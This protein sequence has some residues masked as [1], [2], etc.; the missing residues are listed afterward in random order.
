MKL[1][2]RWII[3]LSSFVLIWGTH[4][5]LTP[6]SYLMS[7]RVLTRHMRDIMENIS[8]LTLEQSYNHLSKAKSAASLAK[9]LLSSN[10]VTSDNEG[11]RAL[12]RYFFDQL[13]I[14]PHLAGIY[15]GTPEGNFFYVSRYEE[16]VK[17]GFRTKIIRHT[18][19]GRRTELIYRNNNFNLMTRE[20]D[21][22][23]PYDPRTRPWFKNVLEHKHVAWT[24]PYIFYTSQKPGITIAGP[25]Y[26]EKG[27]LKGIVG[28]DI[29]I[30][31]LSLFVSKLRVGKSGKAF[32][33]NRN[34]DV[35]AYENL[36]KHIVGKNNGEGL[37][38][39]KV[40]EL[41]DI[42]AKKAFDSVHWQHD[43]EGNLELTASTFASFDHNG[44][45]Y[46]SMFTPFPA[47]R[48]PWIIGVY[49]PEDDYLGT[50][51]SNRFFNIIA[52]VVISIIASI[53]GLIFAQKIIRPVERLAE[54]AKAIEELDIKTS[55][56]INSVFK[57]LQEAANSFSRMK[58]SLVNYEGKLREN[59]R[60]YMAI[61]KTANDAI[62]MMDDKQCIS[63]LNPAAEKMFGYTL[64]ESIGLNLH[65]LFSPKRNVPIYEKGLKKFAKDGSG[66]FIDR[67]VTVQA[68]NQVG[69]K[70]PVE[71]S[72]SSLKIND[73][74]HA[75][76][77][78]RNITERKKA[79]QLRKRLANDLHDGIG[80]S[81][82]N[83]KLFAEMTMA[84]DVDLPTKNNLDAIAAISDDCLTEIRHYMNIL[85]DTEP[86]W[87]NF[88]AELHQ[89]CARTLEPH[90]ISFSMSTDL[91]NTAPPP[92][93]V[94][95]INVFKI[96]KEAVNNVIKHSNGDSM[97]LNFKVTDN[98]IL[99]IMSDNGTAAETSK[100][101]GRGLLSMTSR[102]KELG[103]LLTISWDGGV[104]INL[105]IP[106]SGSS[107]LQ[108][109]PV[110]ESVVWPVEDF[111]G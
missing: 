32:I 95:Y 103:G 59:N 86:K 58:K 19:E 48:L 15:V 11:I 3:F 74:W 87:D 42:I 22:D 7:E 84:H 54:E 6:S 24:N 106:F 49:L 73:A 77:I 44:D 81:L 61:T 109:K 5:I 100:S 97:D 8:D 43:A 68:I 14:Y 102:A 80:G 62:V 25:S 76:A 67:T 50:I 60:L 31:E 27:E 72:L 78:I 33:L 2:I 105:I 9:Q 57:E 51:K 30:A 110:D 53:L 75:V 111:N 66:P 83:I 39:P 40:N 23:D 92:T 99:C 52:T 37:R 45:K 12:E 88:L 82:T 17:D 26:D 56:H 107:V 29:E 63:Y 55:V 71:L 104:K 47:E 28:V 36:G 21:P 4:L 98:Q 91:N 70:F 69:D 35:I 20:E 34:S 93:R 89:Y 65:K 10:V 96:V 16:L 13:S 46:L 1:S 38:L 85:D 79:E 94:L 90:E 18:P 41:K 101:T 108:E 64:D